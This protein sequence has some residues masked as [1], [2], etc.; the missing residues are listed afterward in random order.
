MFC[1][2]SDGT[3]SRHSTGELTNITDV[4]D[5]SN[6]SKKFIINNPFFENFELFKSEIQCGELFYELTSKLNTIICATFFNFNSIFWCKYVNLCKTQ[7]TTLTICG[8]SN[9]DII[10]FNVFQKLP[11]TLCDL[12][13][14]NIDSNPWPWL[15][16]FNITTL[17]IR[18]VEQFVSWKSFYRKNKH[19]KYTLTKLNVQQ[20]TK[21]EVF[22]VC[23]LFPNIRHI[24]ATM[25]DVSL[26]LS[27][28]WQT[29]LSHFT[30]KN[31][32][33]VLFNV[34]QLLCI[35]KLCLD[36]RRR[37]V[38]YTHHENNEIIEWLMCSAPV[39]VLIR[40]IFKIVP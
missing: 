10:F 38:S 40:V 26:S 35:R 28:L 15:N 39:W 29:K 25:C 24:N 34:T 16:E 23:E 18:S 11:S 7:L 3:I 37:R 5:M 30:I 8:P 9:E 6:S 14:R 4:I 32:D 20:I 36:M 31:A 19:E 12:T 13:L 1:L 2:Y 27:D 21:E 17:T 22:L 33:D